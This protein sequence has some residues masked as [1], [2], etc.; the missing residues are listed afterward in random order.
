MA[1]RTYRAMYSFVEKDASEVCIEEGDSLIVHR[2]PNG[3][4]QD[5]MSEMT[6]TNTRTGTI[7]TF[8]GVC[9]ELVSECI[10]GPVCYCVIYTNYAWLAKVVG[11]CGTCLV[12]LSFSLLP[13]TIFIVIN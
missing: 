12:W 13:T 5:P 7:V 9:V 1:Y 6:G 10:A 2:H 8:P 3:E 11:N 4:W